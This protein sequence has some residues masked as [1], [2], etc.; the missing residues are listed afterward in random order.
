MGEDKYI[1]P[2]I[3]EEF[4]IRILKKQIE[5]VPDFEFKSENKKINRLPQ[6]F[7]LGKHM[8]P[9]GKPLSRVL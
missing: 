3:K 4:S 2:L 5:N 7:K 6:F 1:T 8:G 9:K